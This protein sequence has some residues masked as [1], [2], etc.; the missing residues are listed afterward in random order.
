VAPLAGR[1]DRRN[2]TTFVTT[3]E[4]IQRSKT[5]NYR[6]PSASPCRALRLMAAAPGAAPATALNERTTEDNNKGGLS[7]EE[8]AK[9]KLSQPLRDFA[10]RRF[11]TS[12]RDAILNQSE[13]EEDDLS[14]RVPT[15]PVTTTSSPTASAADFRVKFPPTPLDPLDPREV[16]EIMRNFQKGRRMHSDDAVRLLHDF[17]DWT[18]PMA[19]L[20]EHCVIPGEAITVIGDTHGQLRDVLHIFNLKGYP[21]L[22]NRFIF[23]GDLVD[24]GDFGVEV[25]LIAMAWCLVTPGKIEGR[26]LID[27]AC[28]I[29]RGNH[30]GNKS[31]NKAYGFS[32]SNDTHI[33]LQHGA[34]PTHHLLFISSAR[35]VKDKYGADEAA[36]SGAF[37]E[38]FYAL[39]LASCVDFHARVDFSLY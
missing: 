1:D 23:N 8:A 28:F 38:A 12:L 33:L 6:F 21:S 2:D 39:P 34:Q 14:M 30:E 26:R 29:Q 10:K 3:A 31:I 24:R 5:T 16:V 22:T 27:S 9:K 11:T 15:A 25:S 13:A 17:R 37:Q 7:R 4:T 18:T 20:M 19:S 36:V 32:T 35:E